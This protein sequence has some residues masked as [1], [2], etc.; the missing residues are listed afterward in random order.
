VPLFQVLFA[1]GLEEGLNVGDEVGERLSLSDGPPFL[2]VVVPGVEGVVVIFIG[3]L[4]IGVLV[5]FL[6][7]RLVASLLFLS[8][9]KEPLCFGILVPV[10]F[11]VVESTGCLVS[12]T[13]V[14]LEGLLVATCGGAGCAGRLF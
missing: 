7:G 13:L 5:F 8:G 4:S 11:V 12:F 1:V 3:L 6:A 2:P 10:G 14:V 9:G